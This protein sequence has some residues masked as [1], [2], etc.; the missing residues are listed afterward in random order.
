MVGQGIG[1]CPVTDATFCRFYKHLDRG[2]NSC[3][4]TDLY[5]MPLAGSKLA[6]KREEAVEKA[7]REAEQRAREEREREKEK[8][9][10]RERERERE[11]E[12]ERAAVSAQGGLGWACRGQWP[13]L[14]LYRC[15]PS[16]GDVSHSGHRAPQAGAAAP[17]VLSGAFSWLCSLGSLPACLS[18]SQTWP[19]RGSRRGMGGTASWCQ[20]K[21]GPLS[22]SWVWELPWCR[23]AAGWDLVFG[24]RPTCPSRSLAPVPHTHFPS[25]ESI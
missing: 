18:C 23:K 5:F 24:S 9:K 8:E 20:A 7:K 12:A 22:P 15:P 25:A 3:A 19:Q 6:K 11:R 2:Y 1:S 4:R 21:A 16:Q 17:A 13:A 14:G 10:E